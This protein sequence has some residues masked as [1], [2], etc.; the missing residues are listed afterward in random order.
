MHTNCGVLTPRWYDVNCGNSRPDF[1]S[2]HIPYY[3]SM[4]CKWAYNPALPFFWVIVIDAQNKNHLFRSLASVENIEPSYYSK[5][6]VRPQDLNEIYNKHTQET[7]GCIFAQSVKIPGESLQATHFGTSSEKGNGHLKS[8]GIENRNNATNLEITF[9]ETNLS[10]ADTFIRP[11]IVV[12]GYKGLVVDDGSLKGA[13]PYW[14]GSIKSNIHIYQLAKGGDSMRE[15]ASCAPSYIRKEFHFFDCVPI[16][17]VDNEVAQESQLDKR[18]TTFVYNYYTMGRFRNSSKTSRTYNG[19]SNIRQFIPEINPNVAPRTH[20]EQPQSL[21]PAIQNFK[22]QV[23]PS[24]GRNSIQPS[25]REFDTVNK[26]KV[27]GT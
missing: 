10:F 14:G 15:N 17:L 20:P 21:D 11:W 27:H 1:I 8:P 4:L 23:Y 22:D 12:A 19:E 13:A 7:I 3:H 26:K 9:T 16:T 6:V 25:Q 18:Q 24:G 5:W 2:N